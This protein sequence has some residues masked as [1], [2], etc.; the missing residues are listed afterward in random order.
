MDHP[1]QKF[2]HEEKAYQNDEYET[3]MKDETQRLPKDLK[4][5]FGLKMKRI[6][7]K[8]RKTKEHMRKALNNMS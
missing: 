7:T 2:E 6:S 4:K 8:N 1:H 5:N 3:P